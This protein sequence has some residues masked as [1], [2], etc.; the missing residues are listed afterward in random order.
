[1][2]GNDL[3]PTSPART[4]PS[5]RDVAALPARPLPSAGEP[6]LALPPLR[7]EGAGSVSARP[8]TRPSPRAV[9]LFNRGQQAERQGDVSGARRFYTSAAQQG[10]AAAARFLG[11]LYDEAYLKQTA[12]GGIEPDAALA[13]QWYE[14]AIAMGDAEAGPLLEA[15][16]LR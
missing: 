9:E 15:L 14:K 10:S 6:S 11:R 3:A 4:D 13:R 12:M 5:T 7:P 8:S 1:M 16:S 2:A